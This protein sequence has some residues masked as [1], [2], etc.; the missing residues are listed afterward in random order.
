VPFPAPPTDLISAWRRAAT[1]FQERGIALLDRRG[2]S[3]E[4]RLY[5]DLVDR[6]ALQARRLAVRGTAPGDRVVVSLGTSWEWLDAW[7]GALFLGALPVALAP[8]EGLGSQASALERAEAIA[9]RLEASLFVCG[10]NVAAMVRDPA[11][12][13]ATP[14]LARIAAT[15]GELTSIDVRAAAIG[16]SAGAISGGGP[17]RDIDPES[18]A[19]LQLT[20]G[21]TGLPRAASIS[22]RAIAH[23]GIASAEALGR[24]WGAPAWEWQ[25]SHV[26][27]LPLHHDMGLV[28]GI[29]YALLNGLDLELAS[30][31]A[32]LG[33]PR[34][35]LELL[36]R[37][38]RSVSP[39]PNFAYQ[40][41]V[42]RLAEDAV[43]GTAD[44]L[45][46][47][48]LARV[49][50]A[51]LGAEMVRPETAASFAR[52][53]A[54]AG[55]DPR[56]MRP[57]YGLAEAT[58]AVTFDCAGEGVRTA[59]VPDAAR[60]EGDLGEVVSVGAPIADTEVRVA[61]ADGTALGEGVVGEV[62][63]NGPG[64]FS[65]YFNDPEATR[66]SLLGRW[67][68]TGDLGFL[69]AGEL[70]LSGRTKDV[71][72]V[73]G[74]NLMPHQI[75]W[76]VEEAAGAGGACR[77]GAFSVP[78]RSGEEPVVV[79]EIDAADSDL[80]ALEREIRGRIGRRLGL[81]LADVAFV[82]RGKIPKTTSGKVQR[83]E[84]R[85]RYLAQELERLG[86]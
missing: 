42:D 65:G 27:W 29:V 51:L 14:M 9:G 72:I 30:P 19:F 59:P 24:P 41:C 33:R 75:E 84:L 63:V 77:A 70:Y 83:R 13:P 52:A 20:S 16:P 38:G 79:I 45:N 2:R 39:A 78:L 60:I 81:V 56:A 35:W 7:F 32:F 8:P 53:F 44:P 37:A 49:R 1:H 54:A 68:R 69:R 5:P 71:L 64:V 76:I 31:R 80:G 36:S 55:L 3:A 22:H 25:Q 67:L 28:G 43:A 10:D 34:L 21:S 62:W 18:T 6:F 74:Q 23:N 47:L 50:A 73:R 11:A 58:L 86:S 61:A 12:V 48:D 57:C 85:A 15:P 46:G 40:L 82:R 4:R 26:L 17:S 66:E